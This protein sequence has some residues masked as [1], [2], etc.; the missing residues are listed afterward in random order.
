MSSGKND[1]KK[2]KK[3]IRERFDRLSYSDINSL[4][5]SIDSLSAKIQK[6]YE[7]DKKRADME[8][9]IFKS[10]LKV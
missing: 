3:K 4:N 7:Y 8:L 1:W 6:V 9:K 10:S 2:L 5:G